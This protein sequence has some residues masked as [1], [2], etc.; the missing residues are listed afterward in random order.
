MRL[1]TWLAESAVL[2]GSVVFA[3]FTGCGGSNSTSP[4]PGDDG[5]DDATTDAT[6]MDTGMGMDSTKAVCGDGVVEGLEQCDDGAKNGT[7]GDG[8]TSDCNWVCASD[9]GMPSCNT[10]DICTGAGVCTAMHT[11]VDGTPPE[12]GT[13]CGTG[14]ICRNQ[15]CSPGVCGDGIVTS[16]EECDDGSKNGT[17]GEGG[18]ID[19]NVV[20]PADTAARG[21]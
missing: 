21:S 19:L 4:P 20:C 5:G 9:G 12:A 2:A 8:C 6:S 15:A 10:G 1:A 3:T 18:A 16:P 7:A 14:M 11:C 13:A 17:A